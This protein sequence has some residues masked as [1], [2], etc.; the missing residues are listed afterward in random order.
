MIDMLPD[1]ALL[2]IFE[3]YKEDR[4]SHFG[5]SWSWKLLTHV[6]RRWRHIIFESPRRLD[7]RIICTNTTPTKTSLDIWPPFPISVMCSPSHPALDEEG[8]ENIVAALEHRDRLSEIKIIDIDDSGLVNLAEVMQEPLPALRYFHLTSTDDSILDIP[9][10]FLGGSAPR[11]QLFI[12]RGIPFPSFPEFVVS[13][14]CIV[15]L[16]LSDIPPSGYITPDD[17]ATCLAALP[18]LNYFCF[19]FRFP[20]SRPFYTSSP[21]VTRAV[22]PALTRLTLDGASGYFEDFVA[23][24]DTPLLKRLYVSFF[25]RPK[26]DIPQLH[27]FIDRTASLRPFKQ[28]YMKISGSTIMA[29]FGSPTRFKAEIRCKGPIGQMITMTMMLRELPLLSYVEQLEIRESRAEKLQLRD[30]L[31]MISPLC[32]WLGMLFEQLVAVQSLYVSKR[33]ARL[34]AGALEGLVEY[35]DLTVFP[36]LRNIFLEEPQPS[37]PVQ[38]GFNSFVAARQLSDCPVVIQRWER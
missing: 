1:G 33:L 7:L 2:D 26:F 21:P 12:L 16:D 29:I 27:D 37:G 17:M 5:F 32:Q 3:F 20:V 36:A 31:N 10:T 9:G 13:S 8:V 28:A 14:N 6:C 34:V 38:E 11:V 15:F 4:A 25:K 23:R 22:L 24:I 35:T 30:D 18:K 19:G